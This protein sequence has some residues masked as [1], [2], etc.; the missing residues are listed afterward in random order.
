VSIECSECERDLRGGHDPSCS[1]YVR[2][3]CRCGHLAEDHDEGWW[4]DVKDCKCDEFRDV[5][6]HTNSPRVSETNNIL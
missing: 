1:R 6:E 2:R 5:C 3:I 4:C